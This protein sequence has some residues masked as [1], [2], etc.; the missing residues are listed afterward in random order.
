M[1]NIKPLFNIDPESCYYL[2]PQE[3]AE[4]C[5]RHQQKIPKVI[6]QDPTVTI[7][8]GLNLGDDLFFNF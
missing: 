6:G 5:I 2:T 4:R 7:R 1:Y 8:H 3:I